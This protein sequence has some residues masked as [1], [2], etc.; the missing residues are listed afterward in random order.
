MKNS[1]DNEMKL[2]LLILKS[3]EKEYNSRN[4]AE[5]MGISPMGALKIARRLA[6]EGILKAKQI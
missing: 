1:K 6:K 5:L 2:V 3:P 4:L